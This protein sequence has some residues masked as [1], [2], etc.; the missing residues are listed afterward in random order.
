[1]SAI[2]STIRQQSN[3]KHAQEKAL[4]DYILSHA[5]Q[6][7]RMG[8]EELAEYS[9]TSTATISR[10]CKSLPTQ[11]FTDF[12][13]QLATELAAI[14]QEQ[15][16]EDI[17]AMRPLHEIVKVIESNHLLTIADTTRLIDLQQL[18]SAIHAIHHAPRIDIYGVGTSGVVAQ[19]FYQKL[20]RIGKM[21]FTSSDLH[22]Q[23]TSASTLT[24]ADCAIAIS[25]SGETQ[26]TIQSFACAKEQG[27]T[28]ISLTKYGANP[29]SQLADI[30]LFTSTQEEGMRRG[31]MASR[32]AQLHL[33]DIVF[34][35]LV[36][37]DFDRSVPILE[38][39]YHMVRK[40]R[41]KGK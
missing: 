24:S 15:T 40:Y 21:S 16:Y 7:V 8:I 13:L 9:K 38:K 35:G 32:I 36:S 33:L 34:M 4:I 25:Y 37:L 3:H 11:G 22:M 23:I 31:D 27:A 1:M 5:P 28:T 6:V 20:V 30:S 19:D 26:E 39:T 14:T 41:E 17:V 2:L 29:L 18:E 12:K 10:F